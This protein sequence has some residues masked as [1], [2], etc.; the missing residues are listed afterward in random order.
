MGHGADILQRVSVFAIFLKKGDV[1]GEK[2]VQILNP[3]EKAKSL[4]SN[5]NKTKRPKVQKVVTGGVKTRKPSPF[6]RL[7]E[8]LVEGDSTTVKQYIFFDVILPG[9]KNIIADSLINTVNMVLFGEGKPASSVKRNGSRSVIHY[10][11][12]S[13]RSEKPKRS[14]SSRSRAKQDFKEIEMAS[15]GEAEEVLSQLVD[16]TVDYEQATVSDFYASVGITPNYNDEKWGW[17]DLSMACVKRTRSG[18]IIDLP[19]PQ[20]LD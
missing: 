12:P 7:K 11:K 4:P 16:L 9:I 17:E 5:S 13:Y 2:K 1:M 6:K 15:R 18:Y 10:D 19:S 14:I 3:R 8:N 20:W